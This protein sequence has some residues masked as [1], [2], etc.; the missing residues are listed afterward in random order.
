MS[1]MKRTSIYL[2]LALLGLAYASSAFAAD[3]VAPQPYPCLW[4]SGTQWPA[5]WWIFPLACFAIMVVMLL[6]MLRRGGMGCMW[7]GPR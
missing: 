5:F 1:T 6:F 7:R 3:P 2:H 4:W